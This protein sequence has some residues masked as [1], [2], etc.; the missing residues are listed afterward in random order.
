MESLFTPEQM[1]KIKA[2]KSPGELYALARE[3]NFELDEKD[4]GAYFEQLHKSSELS[5]DELSCVAGGACYHDGWLVTTVGDC[6]S[7]WTCPTC[8]E[9]IQNGNHWYHNLRDFKPGSSYHYCGAGDKNYNLK[10]DNCKYCEYT[11]G[12]WLC[13]N[14]EKRK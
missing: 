2:A 6:C 9:V 7:L 5:D 14:P 12:L 3:N 8:G 13:K 11:G 10:C 4:A 1:E